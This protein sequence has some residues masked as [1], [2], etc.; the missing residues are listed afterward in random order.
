[1]P[2]EFA[3]PLRYFYFSSL[4]IAGYRHAFVTRHGGVSQKPWHSLN[5]GGS[6]GDDPARVIANKQRVLQELGF[7]KESAFDV[8]QVHGCSVAVASAPRSYNTPQQ[9]ADIILTDKPCITLMMRFADCVPILLFDPQHRVAGIV[10]SGWKGTIRKTAL[11]AV[12]SMSQ[13]FGS[14]PDRILAA[15]GP[16]IGPDHYEVGPEV[17]QLV[18]HSFPADADQ[19]LISQNGVVHF[20]LWRANQSLLAQGGVQNVE[21]AELCTACHVEDWFSHRAE[22][23]ITGRFAVLAGLEW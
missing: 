9:Q 12:Q 15:I 11:T 8:W 17:V 20:D 14:K 22:N 19:F 1:M 6:V 7:G 5:L 2:Y 10:H 18:K 4:R 23:G 16:S 13:L 21:V 3:G